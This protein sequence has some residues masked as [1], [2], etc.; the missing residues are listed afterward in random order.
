[1][2][3]EQAS[4]GL[5]YHAMKRSPGLRGPVR[6]DV[7]DA[8]RTAEGEPEKVRRADAGNAKRGLL[9]K[10]RLTH[11]IRPDQQEGLSTRPDALMTVTPNGVDCFRGIEY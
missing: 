4:I 3:V 9:K 11:S 2:I 6:G 10:G 1:V 5:S 7:Q 8:T